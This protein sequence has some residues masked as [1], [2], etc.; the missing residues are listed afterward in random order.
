MIRA[1][2]WRR[3]TIIRAR[4][5]TTFVRRPDIVFFFV[6]RKSAKSIRTL[7]NGICQ[8]LLLEI[9]ASR[10]QSLFLRLLRVLYGQQQQHYSKYP[11]VIFG[12][13]WA[14]FSSVEENSTW[15][16]EM[17]T[18]F[19]LKSMK[20]LFLNGRPA[21]A[22]DWSRERWRVTQFIQSLSTRL[23]CLAEIERKQRKSSLIFKFVIA[24]PLSRGRKIFD[25]PLLLSF[26]LTSLD[27]SIMSRDSN[28]LGIW[29]NKD[30]MNLNS[31]VL[32]NIMSSQYFK[33]ALYEKK[34]YHE[35]VD[36]IYY[37]VR[38]NRNHVSEIEFVSL[39]VKHLEP[40]EKGSR[41]TA[42][43]TGMCGGVSVSRSIDR[44]N[45]VIDFGF[46]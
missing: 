3:G 31:L 43:L 5:R 14:T 9:I 19:I 45:G 23:S 33:V 11:M 40:W 25:L 30:S 39:Q 8:K 36:E 32:S 37:R 46:V 12:A 1:L 17:T 10:R 34:T 28:V 6:K 18:I 41:K 27:E 26:R 44:S 4:R 13:L 16:G 20:K 15:R 7:W 22:I 42:G 38:S 24:S 21:L 35:V 2:S 29:G